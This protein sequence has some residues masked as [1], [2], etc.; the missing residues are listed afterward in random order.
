M[1]SEICNV[2]A[3]HPT[4]NQLYIATRG[5]IS[6]LDLT[7][8]EPP[9]S[10]LSDVYVYPNPIR[11]NKGHQSLKIGNLNN[12]LVDVKIYTLE[13]ELV[14]ESFNVGS[15]DDVI[16]DL[17]TPASTSYLAAPGVYVVH[18]EGSSGTVVK[19]VSLIR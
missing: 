7:S 3:L 18:I 5:G 10:N 8:L 12:A 19:T 4:K 14:Y 15:S 9:P 2:I 17:T 13:G 6:I 16:W 11:A 1:V